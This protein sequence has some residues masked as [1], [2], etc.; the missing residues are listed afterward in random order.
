MIGVGN[1]SFFKVGIYLR[2]SRDD[3]GYG[4]SESI[5]N[6]KDFLVKYV[7]NKSN[8]ILVD[9]YQDDGYTGTN[10]DRPDF[11]RMKQDVE[12]GKINLIITKDLSRLGRDYIDTGYYVEKY[13]PSKQVRYIAVN[14]GVDTFEK[15][16]S[17]NDMGAFKFVVNDMYAKDISKKV[18]T[19]IR[20][21]AEKG[22]YIG[23]FTPYGYKKCSDDKTKIEIDEEAA[24]NVRFI[25]NEYANGKGLTYIANELNK[26]KILCPSIYKQKTSNFHCKTRSGLWGHDTVRKI[27]TNRVYTGDLEQRKGEVISYKVKKYITLP[28]NEHIIIQD[29]HEAIIDKDTFKLAQDILHLKAHK[30]SHEQVRTHLLSGLLYCPRCGARYKYQIQSGM[31]EKDMVAICSNYTRHGKD[32]CERIGMRESVLNQ[33]VKDDLRRLAKEKINT[34]ELEK[35]D[36]LNARKREA[37]KIAKLK[38]D[39]ERRITDIDRIIKQSYEDKVLG[40]I[41]TEEFNEIITNYRMEKETLTEKITRYNNEINNTSGNKKDDMVTQ[42]IKSITDFEN[43][44]KSTLLSLIEK[45]EIIDKESIKIYYRF[46]DSIN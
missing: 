28:D 41:T 15:Y 25:F 23:A 1:E 31:K 13:F 38:N 21:K 33:T 6:Q 17:N 44:D 10:F 32:Y 37:S 18:R 22:D 36:G 9:I 19:A 46:N 8:W 2:L 20:T 4:T 16:N 40:V 30:N 43:V 45:I 7:S 5:K 14:D 3:E 26:R 35:I 42:I 27:L 34:E 24:E 12:D 39:C 11:I 29:N